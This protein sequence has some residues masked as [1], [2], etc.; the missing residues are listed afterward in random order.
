[1]QYSKPVNNM[2]TRYGHK[3]EP[4]AQFAY[5]MREESKHEEFKF[6][7]NVFHVQADHPYLG[8]SPGGIVN[9]K[10]HGC[11]LLEIICPYSYQNCLG[12]WETDPKFPL[13]IDKSI[14][15]AHAYY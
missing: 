11:K 5:I 4:E 12:C 15:M 1:M 10:Y 6:C 8:A 13:N 7:A 9:C 14:K 2:Y 3:Y